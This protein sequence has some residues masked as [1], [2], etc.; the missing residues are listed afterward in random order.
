M[1]QGSQV[2]APPDGAAATAGSAPTGVPQSLQ[3]RAPAL[4]GAEQERQVDPPRAAPH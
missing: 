1:V 4:R 3:K 2:L